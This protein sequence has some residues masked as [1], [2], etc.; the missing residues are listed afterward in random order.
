MPPP[1]FSFPQKPFCSLLSS[2][3]STSPKTEI[4]LFSPLLF[5]GEFFFASPFR[6]WFGPNAKSL[7]KRT[8]KTKK[9][10]GLSHSSARAIPEN[11]SGMC[12]AVMG[13][14]NTIGIDVWGR[15][16]IGEWALYRYLSAAE[17]ILL[18]YAISLS[19]YF[20]PFLFLL[21]FWPL[22]NPFYRRR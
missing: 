7:K 5:S 14:G 8:K 6:L 19:M 4:S 10:K 2:S 20:P 15:R 13:F 18:W 21:M 9:E 1:P 3:P 12:M 16:R 17:G 11:V 22:T